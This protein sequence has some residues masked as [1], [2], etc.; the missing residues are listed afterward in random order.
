M[1]TGYK[2]VIAIAA[3]GAALIAALYVITS[4]VF[5]PPQRQGPPGLVTQGTEPRLWLMVKQEE[6]KQVSGPAGTRFSASSVR[7]ETRYHFELR[8]HDTKTT[9]P[10]WKKRLLTL[11]EKD[12]GHAAQARILGQDRDSVWLFVHDQ[13][14][15]VAIADGAVIADRARIEQANPKLKGLIPSELKFYTYDN[16]LVITTADARRIYVRGPDYVATS[17][18]PA[19]EEV[20]RHLAFMS[21]TWNGG[22]RTRDFLLR[23]GTVGGRWVGLY[24]DAEA[25]DAA[26]DPSGDKLKDPRRV[27][28]E[29]AMARRSFWTA[30]I[31]KSGESSKGRR[32]RLAEVVRLAGAQEML[33]AGM[34][35][36]AGSM[37]PLQLKNPDGIVVLY[38]T[39]VDTEG[40]LAIARLDKDFRE[41]WTRILPFPEL[42]NRW[43]F[44]DRLLLMGAIQHA[45]G[46][47]SRW[48]DF[49]V[50]L[51][52]RDGRMQAWN[53]TFE[54]S[55]LTE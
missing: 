47:V 4:S 3:V 51:D 38:R 37:D 6:R 2:V 5:E 30:R 46:G 1:K 45:E 39:R 32:D 52:L 34:L 33:Q 19:S 28:D 31:G 40:R 48:Q 53:L 49:I 22:F 55:Q 14:I 21:T 8:A 35:P 54:R 13:P 26:N 17:Y 20:F 24:S 36:A 18:K 29:G 10:V 9:Q 42:T 15:A 12:G 50:A 41:Q 43:E 16:G 44:P 25:A 7:W 23:H 27:R 11:R